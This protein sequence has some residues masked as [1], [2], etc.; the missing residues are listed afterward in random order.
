MR[1]D[2]LH[3]RAL[4]RCEL[5]WPLSARASAPRTKGDRKSVELSLVIKQALEAAVLTELMPRSQLDV[6]IQV[7]QADGGVR[8]AANAAVLA[9]ADAGVPLRDTMAACSAGYLDGT[10]P[11]RQTPRRAAARREVHVAAQPNL[12]KVVLL[13]MDNKCAM[14]VFELIHQLALEG[15]KVVVGVMRDAMLKRT[16]A[17][18]AARANEAL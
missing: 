1:S 8:S 7:L 5:A 3:D 12:E 18:A 15:C 9:L 11:R 6:N 13:Q 16:R 14:D 17:L 2:A 10:L 4:V